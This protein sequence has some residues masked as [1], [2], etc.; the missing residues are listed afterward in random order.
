M[1]ASETVNGRIDVARAALALGVVLACAGC[2]TRT[3][4]VANSSPASTKSTS[5]A[6]AASV[7]PPPTPS[8]VST[9]AKLSST[10]TAGFV[11]L[12]DGG[13]PATFTPFSD[14]GSYPTGTQLY[15]GYQVTLTNTSD[16]TAEVGSFSVVFYDEGTE[17]GSTGAD[18]N[19]QFITPGQSLSWTEE[20]DLMNAGSEGAVGTT[21]TCTLVQWYQ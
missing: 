12:G 17:L 10:C 11:T 4:T 19:D 20:T 16:V 7:V 18:V 1:E 2:V 15:G 14:S 5:P 3:V 21:D 6:A 13:Q 9:A 8:P